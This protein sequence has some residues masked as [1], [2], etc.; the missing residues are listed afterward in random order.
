MKYI[1]TM[2]A[3]GSHIVTSLNNKVVQVLDPNNGEEI[4]SFF[5]KVRWS[6]AQ[7]CP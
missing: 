6:C 7:A 3:P 5:T 2:F 1:L 4:I